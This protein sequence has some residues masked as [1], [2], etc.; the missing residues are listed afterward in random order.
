MRLHSTSGQST[1]SVIIA[2]VGKTTDFISTNGLVMPL[3]Y[4]IMAYFSSSVA[5]VNGLQVAWYYGN[6][7]FLTVVD[8]K[9]QDILHQGQTRR[10]E[11]NKSF[12]YSTES[13]HSGQNKWN[14]SPKAGR[15]ETR[16]VFAVRWICLM[17][18]SLLLIGCVAGF[19]WNVNSYFG[20]F[21]PVSIT[22]V[23]VAAKLYFQ[24]CKTSKYTLGDNI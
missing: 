6:E 21:G 8:I 22:C 4:V 20:L 9:R 13:V 17:I 1:G 11:V 15:K 16:I 7:D 12:Q 14:D 3:Q 18:L 2:M 23:I 19:V 24:L 10:G 5:Y